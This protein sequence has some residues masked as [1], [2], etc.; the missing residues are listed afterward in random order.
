MSGTLV[1][2]IIRP[3]SHIVDAWTWWKPEVSRFKDLLNPDLGDGINPV[4]GDDT[5]EYAEQAWNMAVPTNL[6]SVC[7]ITINILHQVDG[8]SLVSEDDIRISI[9]GV[10]LS[11]K[12][13]NFEDGVWKWTTHSW[14]GSWSNDDVQNIKVAVRSPDDMN[15]GIEIRIE[16]MYAVLIGTDNPLINDIQVTKIDQ[17]KLNN[18]V[19]HWNSS[20]KGDEAL[21]ELSI[22][23]GSNYRTIETVANDGSYLLSPLRGDVS[24]DC[25]VRITVNNNSFV[26]PSF[27][28]TRRRPFTFRG[29]LSRLL[30]LE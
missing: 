20:V 16:S 26:S 3:V 21:V 14:S 28:I 15:R 6:T 10:W 22:D 25:V 30:G 4:Y 17:A 13:L 19:I 1:S 11:P 29:S 5:N 27:A 2:E 7:G 24:N 9:G 18:W 12:T 23:G 8:T